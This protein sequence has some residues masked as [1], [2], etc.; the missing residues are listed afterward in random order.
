MLH[1]Q[2]DH[3]KLQDHV[4]NINNG[5]QPVLLLFSVKKV[6]DFVTRIWNV[7]PNSFEEKA[8]M[9]KMNLLQSDFVSVKNRLEIHL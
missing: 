6:S 3:I 9:K 8:E 1:M 7:S 4:K 5:Q 2:N